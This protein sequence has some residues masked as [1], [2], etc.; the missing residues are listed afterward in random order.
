M[1]LWLLVAV[2]LI[3]GGLLALAGQRGDRAAA[4]LGV[5]LAAATVAVAVAVAFTR[6]TVSAP[7]LAGIRAGL[8]VD[9]LSPG[10]IRAW[11]RCSSCVCSG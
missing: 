8:A 5:I 7:L 10:F 1:L 4:E 9:G 6:P 3:G 2:P 11:R